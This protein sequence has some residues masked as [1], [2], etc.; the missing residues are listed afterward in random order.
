M[1]MIDTSVLI[2]FSV[3]S[4]F[5]GMSW[6]TRIKRL[7]I[8]T[9]AERVAT[10][11]VVGVVYVVPLYFLLPDSGNPGFETNKLWLVL[12]LNTLVLPSAL[13]YVPRLV[14]RVRGPNPRI[15]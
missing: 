8:W 2:L 6:R 15:S 10:S 14:A 11:G 1:T 9:W 13:A 12:L 4:L 3:L 5:A 7:E